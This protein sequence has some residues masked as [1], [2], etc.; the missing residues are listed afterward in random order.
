M[1]KWLST[2]YFYQPTVTKRRHLAALGG[3]SAVCVFTKATQP[4]LRSVHAN[5]TIH[6]VNREPPANAQRVA[7]DSYAFSSLCSKEQIPLQRRRR[8]FSRAPILAWPRELQPRPWHD[9]PSPPSCSQQQLEDP[10]T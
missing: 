9:R 4:A 7:D 3:I 8:R 10:P 6:C 5:R 1:L 2:R